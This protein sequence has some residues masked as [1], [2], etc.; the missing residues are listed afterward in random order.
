MRSVF[1]AAFLLTSLVSWHPHNAGAQGSLAI[2]NYWDPQERVIKPNLKGIPRLRFLTVTDFPPF[3]FID[4]DKRLVGFHVDLARAICEELELIDVCQI[5]A[6]PFEEQNAAL[7]D[8]NGEALISGL[9]ITNETRKTFTFSRPYFRLPAR[10]IAR[11]TSRLSEPIEPLLKNRPVGIVA[12]TA[13]AA[14]AR[15]SFTD[16]Q[17]R[18]FATVEDA[19]AALKNNKIEAVFSDGLALSFWIQNDLSSNNGT[20]CCEFAGGPYFSE[21]Y[22]GRGLAIALPKED[23]ELK[24]GID[25]ALRSISEKGIFSEL[26]LRYFP[27]SLY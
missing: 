13:H 24:E 3:S 8:K 11:K 15:A 7:A 23:V 26:Y 2:P 19:L 14:F 20:S 6:I 12:G 18:Q 22:F 4:T 21:A 5:Q 25:Y 10:F 1:I 9:A 16:L 17:L 27:I